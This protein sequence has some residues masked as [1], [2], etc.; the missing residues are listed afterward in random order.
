MAGLR[1][2]CEFGLEILI[3][4]AHQSL[5]IGVSLDKAVEQLRYF[6]E[7]VGGGSG[8]QISK[9]AGQVASNR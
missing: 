3:T 6:W 5:V 9:L 2:R 8:V 4:L 1:P 7:F